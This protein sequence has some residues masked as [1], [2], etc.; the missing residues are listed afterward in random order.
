MP[1]S[2]R[3]RGGWGLYKFE[4]ILGAKPDSREAPTKVS[5]IS[6]LIGGKGEPSEYC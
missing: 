5:I 6:K 2:G 3:D 4:T 1:F